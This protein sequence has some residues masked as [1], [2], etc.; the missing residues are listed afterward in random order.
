MPKFAANL[1]T[2]FN[3]LPFTERFAAAA[4]AGFDAVEFLFPYDYD[5]L[6]I[7]QLLT[8]NHLRLVLFNTLPGDVSAGE[9]GVAA[10]PGRED[11]AREHIRLAL[12]YA[13]ILDCPQVHVMAG[14]VKPGMDRTACEETFIQNMR[15]AA[16]LFAAEG[17]GLLIE[18][19]NPET[20]AHY[21]YQ[22]Q[23]QTLEMVKRIDKPNVTIQLDLFHAQKV[24]GN[25]SKLITEYAGKYRHIQIASLPERH[26]PDEGEINYDWIYNLLD[27]TGYDGW[28]GCEYIP[29]A[30]TESGLKWFAKYKRQ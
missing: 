18:A 11:L 21:L 7:K 8:E 30:D 4:R 10:L 17:K 19:L 22:S 28:I 26:E 23:Y 13:S 15:Y 14:V 20:K 9:W 27:N 6:E 16:D 12:D 3:E 24:D 2:L 29:R 5:A 1:T 25:L